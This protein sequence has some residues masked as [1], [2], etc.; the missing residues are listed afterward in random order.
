MVKATSGGL[1]AVLSIAEEYGIALPNGVLA[2]VGAAQ[3]AGSAQGGAVAAGITACQEEIASVGVQAGAA[4]P[5]AVTGGYGPATA[6]GN[7]LITQIAGGVTSMSGLLTTAALNA[8]NAAIAAAGGGNYSAWEAVGA[9]SM[10]G[11]AAG[12]VA[13]MGAPIGAVSN[14]AVEILTTAHHAIDNPPYPSAV[15]RDEIGA[16]TMVGWAAGITQN[17]GLVISAIT[18][19]ANSALSAVQGNISS[20]HNPVESPAAA[21]PELPSPFAGWTNWSGF[22]TAAQVAQSSPFASWTSAGWASFLQAEQAAGNYPGGESSPDFFPNGIGNPNI[23]AGI[24]TAQVTNGRGQRHR[25]AGDQL[26]RRTESNH[27]AGFAD[28]LDLG[29]HGIDGRARPDHRDAG[30]QG[31]RENKTPWIGA[32][33]R[34]VTQHIDVYTSDGTVDEP[35]NLIG[36]SVSITVIGGGSSLCRGQW[37]LCARVLPRRLSLGPGRSERVPSHH[38]RRQNAGGG[39]GCSGYSGGG[40]AGSIGDI[41]S[42]PVGGGGS[43]GR[44]LRRHAVDR[45]RWR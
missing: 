28:H 17:A 8:S 4:V 24:P 22:V 31:H 45:S 3:G 29:P 9:S 34:T 15:Y 13:N 38:L 37:V 27:R 6:A 35:D 32:V 40:A 41:S 44:R 7:G 26:R 33:G 19:A 21:P 39:D 12:I 36:T 30:E 11:W 14:A 43:F 10:A 1:P 16:S 42:Y 5:Q 23:V 18:T 20:L 25:I 2:Q